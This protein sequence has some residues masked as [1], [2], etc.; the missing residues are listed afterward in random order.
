MVFSYICSLFSFIYQVCY[1]LIIISVIGFVCYKIISYFYERNQ[2]KKLEYAIK[3]YGDD[4]EVLIVGAGFSGLGMAVELQKKGIKYR[5]IEKASEVAGT[6]Y[7]NRY[8][9][10]ACDIP[11][12][13]YSFSYEP[14]SDWSRVFPPQ[15]E[16]LQYL[17][18]VAKK[19]DLYKHIEFNQEVVNCEFNEDSKWVL[20]TK[21][22]QEYIGNVL[23]SGFGGLHVP[24]YPKIDNFENFKGEVM[25]T[26]EWNDDYCFEGKKVGILGS[27][28]SAV[29]A[30]PE[31][32]KS[33]QHM[34]MF[35]RTPNWVAPKYDGEWS[36]LFKK[37][38][39][40]CPFF[41]RAFRLTY[42][43]RQELI[44]ALV[45]YL[46]LPRFQKLLTK[47][48][49]KSVKYD[50][51]LAKKLTPNYKP[52]CKRI[53][54]AN[55]FYPT[56]LRDNVTLETDSIVQ[57][58]ENGIITKSKDTD[59]TKEHELDCIL[60]ATGFKVMTGFPTVLSE[61]NQDLLTHYWVDQ[62]PITY[63]GI[64][65]P[66]F[67]NFFIL[68]GPN[69]GLGHNSV[70]WMIECQVN[71][72]VKCIEELIKRKQKKMVVK[73]SAANNWIDSI[74][75]KLNDS[76]WV[77]GGCKSWY[78]NDKGEPFAL[79]PSSTVRYYFETLFPNFDH[80]DFE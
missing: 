18:G 26:A 30:A 39:K 20:T 54:Q 64:C 71:Y 33:A 59:E 42:Y 68:L 23:V 57:F 47:H 41:M 22:G 10:C 38:F 63:Y 76:I 27:A 12:H 31:I 52:G 29:Q 21:Q 19:Y 51:E 65:A 3:T 34:T 60:F 50:K 37:L 44:F 75:N 53:L 1:Y 8:W 67:P 61:K 16:I 74:Y 58:T 77:T 15:P 28:A 36:P 6:W 48:I 25:H 2:K 70:V 4:F 7:H 46:Q 80:F 72:T 24:N 17:K 40:Y 9:G 66:E 32:S 5:I 11:S 55:N 73:N 79:W 49:L 56:F 13:L 78:Q 14:Y 43:F 69:T 45:F 35:Q 62:K